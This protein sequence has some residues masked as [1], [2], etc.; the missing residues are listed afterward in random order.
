MAVVR[1]VLP[2]NPHEDLSKYEETGGGEGL[3]AARKVDA[4]TVIAEVEASGLR[5]RGGAGF[6]TGTKWRTVAAMWTGAAGPAVVVNAAEGEPG[7]F[8]DRAI[9]RANP[10]AVIEGA[11]I[12]AWSVASGEVVIALKDTFTVEADRLERAIGEMARADWLGGV[13]VSVF[14]GPREYLYGEETGLLEAIA[15]RAPFPR[16][17][18][19]YVEGI[20]E[21][22]ATAEAKMAG[23]TDDP[24]ALVNNV[25]TLANVP[26]ILA[27]GA[28]WFREVG[29]DE[30]PG[31]VVCTISGATRQTGLV[32]LAGGSSLREAIEATGGLR[33]GH[34]FLAALP[35][36]SSAPI[37][38]MDA[39]VSAP[40][41]YIVLDDEED[42]VAAVAGASRFLA[43]ES[44]GQCVPCKRDGLELADRLAKLAR[45]EAD[46][47]DVQMI[48][49]LGFRVSDEARCALGRQHEALVC[50][51]LERF[52]AD[53]EAHLHKR[54]EAVEPALVAPLLD[55]EGTT[56]VVDGSHGDKQP[57]WTH[58]ASDSGK[59][60]AQMY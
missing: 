23:A 8:K 48:R 35:G 44:C 33:A 26:G 54:A 31:T 9:M 59:W 51:F 30:L 10:Y 4:D 39:P 38:D 22:E 37:T 43:I 7:T 27:N 20:L 42:V 53:V 52:D 41:G 12:A 57:D 46:V 34:R 3:A 24:P 21:P 55:I 29:T 16:V 32:E 25:E 56:A 17:P 36:T 40:G 15:G 49:D 28:D 50:G 58:N 5:G 6:P 18:P 1:R 19:P 45:N 60:P 47:Y 13:S 2:E 11:L 14:S